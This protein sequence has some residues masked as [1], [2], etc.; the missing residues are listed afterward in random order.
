[1]HCSG[2]SRR[3]AETSGYIADQYFLTV[4][5][6]ASAYLGPLPL[7]CLKFRMEVLGGQESFLVPCLAQ[8][9]LQSLKKLGSIIAWINNNEQVTASFSSLNSS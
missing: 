6:H 5:L 2:Y 1:M 3:F 7:I 4:S 8:W 9:K